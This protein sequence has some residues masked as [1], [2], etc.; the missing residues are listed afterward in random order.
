MM[1]ALEKDLKDS[2]FS[3]KRL[4]YGESLRVKVL[5]K[6]ICD[7]RAQGNKLRDAEG[8]LLPEHVQPG[9]AYSHLSLKPG[10]VE[11][12]EGGTGGFK[13]TAADA[14]HIRMLL[15]AYRI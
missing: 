9:L 6:N 1:Q 4:S 13:A 7:M 3:W 12:V 10:L 8:Q 2:D 11:F 14:A 15:K 5:Y